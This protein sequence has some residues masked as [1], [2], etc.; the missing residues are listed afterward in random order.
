MGAAYRPQRYTIEQIMNKTKIFVSSTCFDLEQIREDLRKNILE[1]GHDPILSELPSFSVLPDLDTLSNCKRN[2]KENCDIFVLIIGGKRGSIEPN[3]QKSIIN[4]EYDTAIQNN[5][6]VFVFVDERVNNLLEIW[7]KN[8]DADFSPQVD[9]AY[10]FEFIDSIKD[11]KKWIFTYKKADNI[12]DVLKL[13][14]SNYLKY[15]VDRKNSGKL[16][17]LKEFENESERAKLIALE[18]PDFW[19]YKLIA[20]LLKTRFQQIEKKF[21]ELEEGLYF[22]RTVRLNALNYYQQISP[23][24]ADLS[25]ILHM[26]AKV[27]NEEIPKSWGPPGVAG[28]PYEI[29]EAVDKLYAACLAAF[30]WE[31]EM[32]SLEPPDDFQYLSE[33]MKGCSKVMFDSMK[34]LPFKQEEPFLTENPESGTYKIDFE[35]MIP[36]N[37]E[38]INQEIER[39]SNNPNLFL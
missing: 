6:D 38:K 37:M 23:K 18:K 2:V 35:F 7:R 33:L 36:P 31:L 13:Q 19:E 10:V 8:K 21:K 3:S 5:K 29:K 22:I 15:L 26:M 24:F 16:D 9:D 30:D 12:V 20:E 1:M 27:V 17:P 39:L 28:N 32:R 14:L 34:E 25:K 11:N 4:I